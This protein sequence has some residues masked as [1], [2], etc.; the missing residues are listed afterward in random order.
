MPPPTP[1]AAKIF[2]LDIGPACRA[3][4]VHGMSIVTIGS[5]TN[6]RSVVEIDVM[7]ARLDVTD[8]IP[9]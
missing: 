4:A 1:S 5:R 2:S 7:A 3:E 6:A 9:V 8:A